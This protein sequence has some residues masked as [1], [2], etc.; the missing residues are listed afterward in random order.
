MIEE[1]SLWS[2]SSGL[3]TIVFISLIA[4]G[5]T[6]GFQK[7]YDIKNIKKN[8][9]EYRCSPTIMPFASFFG[10]KTAE[11]F[12]FCMGQIF[13]IHASSYLGSFSGILGHFTG[14][15]GTIINSVSSL[16][17]II[18]SLGGGINVVF[19]EFTERISTFFFK[20][21][22][23]A[24]QI[25]TLISRMYAILF[26]VMYMG[27]SGITGL[28]TF[29]NTFLYSFL[30][31]FCFPEDTILNI[32]GKGK[33]PIKDVKI[34]DIIQPLKCRV[35][36]TFRFHAR[37]QPMVKLGN[38]TVSTNH[39]V[40]YNG[41]NIK[42]GEHPNA[43]Q[44]KDWDSDKPLYC[45]NTNNNRIPI[46]DF[47]FLDYDETP[48]AD[49]DTMRYIENRING[50]STNP[51]KYT[52]TEYSPGIDENTKL[53]TK[54]GIKPAKDIQIGDIL[55]TGG[56][57]IGLIRKEVNEYCIVDGEIITPST[58]FW[59]KIHNKWIRIGQIYDTKNETI[60]L[61]SFIVSPNSQLE[62]ENGI[63]I[64]DYMELCSPD[65]EIYYTK[66]LTK[67]D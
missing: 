65:S 54:S 21:R 42:A 38:I 14:I 33:I 11:N 23:S 52:F 62:L 1:H 66:H 48:E 30:D 50:V 27:L 18:A 32:E 9:S 61:L 20:L 57:I 53:R 51:E 67:S 19:Q 64:R 46:D 41:K 25:K 63:I 59:S 55:T 40:E 3:F 13:H 24:I 29:T 44:I 31:T 17:N 7:V 16:R 28:T 43:I 6:Y 36:G 34:G 56:K 58:L 26:S 37:G 8:W 10:H 2:V 60:Q 15:L 22:I 5:L 35:T 47:I 4:F 12:Q 45:L 49:K 39:Y